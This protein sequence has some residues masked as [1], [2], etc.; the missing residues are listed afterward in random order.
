M[1]TVAVIGGGGRSE[2]YCR[3]GKAL[4]KEQFRITAI[5]DPLPARRTLFRNME[6][7][8]V[9]EFSD[10]RELFQAN[11]DGSCP[12]SDVAII[13]TQDNLHFD[14]ALQAMH[15]GYDLLLEKP[16]SNTLE[17]TRKL[18]GVAE[19][20][21]R[22][23]V[24]CHVLRYTPFYRT[25]KDLVDSGRI[26]QVVSLN[27][28][29]GVGAWHQ[30]HSFVRGHWS[31]RAKS[32]PMILAKSCHDLDIIH[33]L[34]GKRCTSISSAGSLM[35]FH[36]GNAPQGAPAR[37]TDGCPVDASCPYNAKRYMADQRAWLTHVF[38]T[39]RTRKRDGNGTATDAEITE[40]LGVSPW[41]RCAYRCDN[42][43]VDHQVVAMDFEG[44]ATGTFTMTAFSE[45][46]NMEIYGTMGVLS[47]GE[48]VKA[49]T[50]ADIILR[51]H[52]GKIHERINI[53][54]ATDEYASHAGG[55]SGLVATLLDQFAAHDPAALH[56]SIADSLHSH[57][58][59]WAAER[60]RETGQVCHPGDA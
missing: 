26:G 15:L 44:G 9:S 42:D 25:V 32:S 11:R 1:L 27:A 30:T 60:S 43:A 20:L 6:T 46:R 56:S 51:D 59:A 33:W 10:Y 19:D 14:P 39:E 57:E 24:V 12:L 34:M 29:E 31:V 22:R 2:T 50:G 48:F 53:P 45:G 5:C 28:T 35:H 4:F 58:M 16:I 47:G 36:E 40:W 13:G 41:G 3:L 7:E 18:A 8:K 17:E 55:D 52:H 23:V 54:E 49:E 37:C 21:E 38:D